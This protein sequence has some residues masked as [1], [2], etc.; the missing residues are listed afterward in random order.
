MRGIDALRA[1]VDGSGRSQ[2]DVSAALGHAPTYV[3]TL[4]A[5]GSQP[6]VDRLAEVASLCG[7]RIQIVGHGEVIEIGDNG[8]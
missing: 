7:Y 2:R 3:S 1:V 6:G 5:Q 4:L 8:E